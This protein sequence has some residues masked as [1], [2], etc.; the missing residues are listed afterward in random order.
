MYAKIWV[1]ININIGVYSLSQSQFQGTFSHES[2]WKSQ[3][4]RARN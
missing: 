4:I 2:L 1:D 3:R